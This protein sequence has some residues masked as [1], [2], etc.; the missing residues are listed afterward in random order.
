M[1]INQTF[2]SNFVK[3]IDIGDDGEN[4]VLT[5]E[6]FDYGTNRDGDVDYTITFREIAEKK[7]SVNSTNRK[8]IAKVLGEET[9]EWAGKQITLY[10]TDVQNPSGDMVPGIRVRIPKPG[11]PGSK[12]VPVPPPPLSVPV[13]TKPIAAKVLGEAGEVR[14]LAKIEPLA[15]IDPTVTLARLR[16]DLGIGRAEMKPTLEMSPRNWPAS[17][18]TD[19]ANW[20][21]AQSAEADKDLPFDLAPRAR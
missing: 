13:A 19:I 15:H 14:L 7:W 5:I 20:L 2:S 3:P 16:N 9:D 11:K 10:V 8:T 12:A 4:R 21:A 17:L 1:N 18:G 6:K